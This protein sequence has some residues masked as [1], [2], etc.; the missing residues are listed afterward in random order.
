MWHSYSE[1]KTINVAVVVLFGH[2][3]SAVGHFVWLQQD[4]AVAR[5]A[6]VYFSENGGELDSADLLL[7]VADKVKPFVQDAMGKRQLTME[8]EEVGDSQAQLRGSF[9]AARPFALA[10]SMT[11]GIY[12]GKLLKYYSNA[13]VATTAE[14][15][16]FIEETEVTGLEVTLRAYGD[17]CGADLW[18]HRPS[19][20]S[21]PFPPR[22]SVACVAAVVRFQGRLL[23]AKVE[24]FDS[25]GAPLEVLPTSVGTAVVK[26]PVDASKPYM[27]VYAKVNYVQHLPG[28]FKD[29]KYDMVDHWATTYGR[30]NST[31]DS[32]ASSGRVPL[33][34]P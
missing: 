18:H 21:P 12:R 14:D 20:P 22:P 24:A 23:D 10:L 2:L 31:H 19:F 5:D 32:L 15:W 27:E 17:Q 11:Y 30:V 8:V 7:K 26:V 1:R 4:P 34:I 33:L 25:K 16:A 28:E 9:S 29:E 13:N 3:L 6:L